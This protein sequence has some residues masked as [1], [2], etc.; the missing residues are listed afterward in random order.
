MHRERG[1]RGFQGCWRCRRCQRTCW[2]ETR[3]K[4]LNTRTGAW[5]GVCSNSKSGTK[6]LSLQK[7]FSCYGMIYSPWT[8]YPA[9]ISCMI[10][11]LTIPTFSKWSSSSTQGVF[12]KDMPSQCPSLNRIPCSFVIFSVNSKRSLWLWVKIWR[13]Q[14]M[15]FCCEEILS[16]GDI[17]KHRLACS[18]KEYLCSAQWP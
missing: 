16:I 6:V 17:V 18:Y 8:N 10:D 2:L 15:R 4:A 1:Y 7:L 13:S 11:Q 12:C 3:L 5:C 14:A 9:R